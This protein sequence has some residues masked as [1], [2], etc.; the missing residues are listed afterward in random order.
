MANNMGY[1]AKA[2]VPHDTNTLGGGRGIYVGGTGDIVC[3][4]ADGNSVTFKAVPVGTQ[5]CVSPLRVKATGT[6]AT[7]LV[8]LF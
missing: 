3:D 5:L 4:F 2:I 6:T 1:T 7:L 8:L